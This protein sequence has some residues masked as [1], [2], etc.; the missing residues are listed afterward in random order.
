M[1][2]NAN[3][4]SSHDCRKKTALLCALIWFLQNDLINISTILMMDWIREL[5]NKK[6]KHKI[7]IYG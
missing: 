7:K 2:L 3:V 6:S 4:L 5:S 1:H